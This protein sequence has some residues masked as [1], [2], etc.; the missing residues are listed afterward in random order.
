MTWPLIGNEA[1]GD[2]V[3]IQTFLLLLCKSS[4]SNATY[5][6]FTW[7]KQR[8]LYQNK[9]TSSLACIPG[10]VTKHTTVKWPIGL[11]E[12]SKILLVDLIWYVHAITPFSYRHWTELVLSGLIYSFMPDFNWFLVSSGNWVVEAEYWMLNTELQPRCRFKKDASDIRS[13]ASLTT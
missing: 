11:L 10:Q 6:A 5:L 8:G 2:L 9:V 7:E 4:C 13:L 12:R 3:L 1:E